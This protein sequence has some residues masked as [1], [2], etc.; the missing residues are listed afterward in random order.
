MNY[1]LIYSCYIAGKILHDR[2]IFSSYRVI[3]MNVIKG[4][5]RLVF[6]LNCNGH[7][8]FTAD[9]ISDIMRV[10]SLDSL[11][12][13][14]ANS[15]KVKTFFSRFHFS[16]FLI[17]TMLGYPRSA[18]DTSTVSWSTTGVSSCII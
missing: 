5:F 14:I 7:P 1:I 18:P 11:D 10:N 17:Q 15:W 2:Q 8:S 6:F 16:Y 4:R 12:K 9:N 13:F 3:K